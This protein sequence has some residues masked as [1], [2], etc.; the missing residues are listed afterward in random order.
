MNVPLCA[1]V[2]SGVSSDIGSLKDNTTMVRLA[3][4]AESN[5]GRAV[6]TAGMPK[7]VA[8]FWVGSMSLLPFLP[9]TLVTMTW[10]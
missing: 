3:E 1:A 9:T 4:A 8:V 6:S 2:G 7:N 10:Y 5:R